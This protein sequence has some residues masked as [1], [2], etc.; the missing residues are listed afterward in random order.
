MP[1]VVPG[2]P[3]VSRPQPS[4]ADLL[5]A[6]GQMDKLGRIEKPKEKPTEVLPRGSQNV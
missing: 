4:E 5:M 3:G 1:L 2:R 6:L